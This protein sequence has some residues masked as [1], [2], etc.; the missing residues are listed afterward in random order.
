MSE[1]V[2][3]LVVGFLT[4]VSAVAMLLSSNAVHSALFLVSTMGGIAF[5]FLLLNAPFLAMIQ[6][7]VYA[8]AIMVLFL[9]VIMLLGA[10]TLGASA[11]GASAHKW[12]YPL[13]LALGLSLMIS[14]GLVI[15]SSGLDLERAPENP[16]RVRV[17]NATDD[18][19]LTL[20]ANGVPLAQAIAYGETSS[21]AALPAGETAFTL[22]A[23][24]APIT[25]TELSL[26]R[27]YT[28]VTYGDGAAPTVAVIAEDLTPFPSAREARLTVF[29]AF[30]EAASATLV[31]LGSDFDDTDTR[32]ITEPLAPG[33][34]S[35][36][37]TLPEGEVDYT[38][39][40]GAEGD[41]TLYRL[42]EFEFTRDTATLLVLAS[43]P[44]FDGT[45]RAFA[46]PVVSRV[47]SAFGSPETIGVLLFT[48]YLMPFLLLALLLLAA[49]V[50]VIVLTHRE[51]E[52]TKR[53]PNVR[54]KVS[55]P[56]ANV[57]AAQVGQEQ[58]ADEPSAPRE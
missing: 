27:T 51:I 26:N 49:M 9:F 55:R 25:L 42:R 37:Q 40:T 39:V 50:G 22:T 36:V 54:R 5:M 19:D 21:Y 29:N 12:F 2:L 10:E 11:P 8:G 48:E 43:E 20:Y 47:N 32:L 23:E 52:A 7:T 31:D 57:I 33:Q 30:P 6:I 44:L 56:L 46:I 18:V 3:F 14:A 38:F 35:T 4:M 41:I 24:G 58:V 16:P 1:Q 45:T 13:A 34:I 53:K 15:V 28:V 17:L